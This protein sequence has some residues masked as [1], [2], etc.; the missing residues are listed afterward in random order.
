MQAL[1]VMRPGHKR[2]GPTPVFVDDD[3]YERLS[4]HYWRFANREPN[5]NPARRVMVNGRAANLMLA[6]EVIGL[7]VGDPR[8][9]FR[10]DTT[11]WDFTRA[12]LRV[13]EP[14]QSPP[15]GPRRRPRAEPRRRPGGVPGTAVTS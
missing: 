5:S 2:D 4:G 13:V 10:I 1:H 14:G 8:R 9:V 11:R 3:V 12:N 7:A 6:R 15:R